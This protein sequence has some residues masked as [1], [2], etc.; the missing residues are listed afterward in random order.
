[1]STITPELYLF[2][3]NRSTYL[4]TVK[5]AVEFSEDIRFNSCS[6][7]NFTVP[8]KIYDIDNEEWITNP[9]YANIEKDRLIRITDDRDYFRYPV[10]GIGT[11][12]DYKYGTLQSRSRSIS[13]YNQ[14]ASLQNFTVQSETR[15]YDIGTSSH[16]MFHHMCVLSCEGEGMTTYDDGTFRDYTSWMFKLDNEHG[17]NGKSVNPFLA[18]SDFIQVAP[19]DVLSLR[20]G[21]CD[22]KYYGSDYKQPKFVWHVLCYSSDNENTFLGSWSPSPTG[23]ITS[24]SS[25]ANY[26]NVN[27]KRITSLLPP[28][29]GVNPMANGGFVRILVQNSVAY[30]SGRTDGSSFYTYNS[31]TGAGSAVWTYPQ[32]GYAAL[33]SGERLCKTI[34]N[35]T[36]DEDIGYDYRTSKLHWFQIVSVD[37]VDDGFCKRKSVKA[38]SYEYS[39]SNLIFSLS[40]STLP[41]YIPPAITDLVNGSQWVIDYCSD[42]LVSTAIRARQNMNTGV[43]NEILRY[44]P[45]WSVKYVSSDLM[46]RYR[47][48]S[49]VDDINVYS[50]IMDT[51]QSTY[52]CIVFFDTDNL[53][54]SAYS[55]NDINSLYNNMYLTWDNSI[56]EINKT[57]V[58]T[59]QF[60]ALC[61]NAGD[62]VYGVGLVNPLGNRMIYNFDRIKPELDYNVSND[63][64]VA[65]AIELWETEY[66]AQY[67]SGSTYQTAALSLI[68]ANMQLIKAEGELS[69]AIEKYK[70][71]ADTINLYLKQDVED[72]TLS[73]NLLARYLLP[74]QPISV[75]AAKSKTTSETHSESL[76]TE[77]VDC[78]SACELAQS[79]YDDAKDQFDAAQATLKSIAA[80]LTM[81]YKTAYKSN[82][83]SSSSHS[84]TILSAD[85]IAE[86]NKYIKIGVWNYEEAAFSE[87]YC[88]DDI[89]TM[90]REVLK[91]SKY[92]LDN[93]LS[94]INYDFSVDNTNI[95]ALDDFDFKNREL[96]MGHQTYV[97]LD[98][99]ETIS[100]ILLEMHVNYFDDDDFSFTFTT[101]VKRKPEH[102]RFA[103]LYSTISQTSVTN[104]Q[105]SFEE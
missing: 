46:T 92:D 84:S 19:Y 7:I 100:P 66:E 80:N 39:L 35:I 49:D 103:D 11:A 57:N 40:E 96:Y 21:A 30:S 93:R 74:A 91:Q 17:V 38:Y 13:T 52:N 34:N 101:D 37:E 54:I 85:E 32:Y 3:Q 95:I 27:R 33:Y 56:T 67:A 51:L 10:R 2:A 89:Y 47:S 23:L 90:L 79:A 26:R 62:N 25:G 75:S 53:T 64:T 86:I 70:A 6:E 94:M 15:L 58:D 18:I 87:T 48:L 50:Y 61:I 69:L 8:E 72:G 24:S 77:L 12:N 88:A 14:N 81:D 1:M 99:N 4:G 9:S 43:L 105:F 20:A 36:A 29:N 59:S 104:N 16:Y 71:Q 83:G 55:L 63:R 45:G 41:F 73:I 28:V 98:K 82:G 60:T 44:L 102:F 42:E 22:T 78:A 31:S 65:E 76:K 97:Q 68:D 5:N